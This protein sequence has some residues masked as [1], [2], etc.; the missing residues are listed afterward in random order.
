MI[1]FLTVNSKVFKYEDTVDGTL[2]ICIH[3][4]N[5]NIFVL[6]NGIDCGRRHHVLLN[7]W[8]CHKLDGLLKGLQTLIK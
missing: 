7:M 3:L 8:V 4:T 1:S 2:Y 6:K 5:T